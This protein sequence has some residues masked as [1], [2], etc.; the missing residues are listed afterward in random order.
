MPAKTATER[1][2]ALR[3][4]RQE[5]GLVRLEVYAHL[6]DHGRIKRYAKRINSQRVATKEQT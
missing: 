3:K 6:Q 4:R 5:Q 2:A 1:V